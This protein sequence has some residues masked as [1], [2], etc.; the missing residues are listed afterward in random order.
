MKFKQIKVSTKIGQAAIFLSLLVGSGTSSADQ[1]HY[2]NLLIGDRAVGLGGAFGAVSDDAS[3]VFYNPAGLGFALSNDVSGSAN[4]VYNRKITYEKAIGDLDFVENTSGTI[5]SFFGILQKLDHIS[6]GLVFALGFYTTDSDLKDQDDL[7]EGAEL[8]S[9][10]TSGTGKVK[11]HRYHRTV[12]VRGST[13]F[14]GIALSKRISGGLSVGLGLT[15][16]SV[17]ELVQE[18]QDTRSQG[19]GA[20]ADGTPVVS[21]LIGHQTQNIRQ[22]LTAT[23]TQLAFGLQWAFA[24]RFSLGITAKGGAWVSSKLDNSFEKMLAG[25]PSSVSDALANGSTGKDADGKSQTIG[26]TFSQV[27]ASSENDDALGSMSAEATVAFAWFIS[28]RALYTLDVSWHD[29]VNDALAAYQKE[30]VLNFASGL[31]YYVTPSLAV[32]LGAFTNNDAR[33]KLDKAAMAQRDH[34]DFMGESMF[35]AWV[36]PNSQIAAGVILQQGKGEAQKTGDLNI[37]NV[38]GDS[39]TF[40]FSTGRTKLS[41]K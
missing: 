8:T 18:Y 19:I 31:E 30:A 33:P 6:K 13:S 35:L 16:V 22:Y 1:F 40:A 23:G 36:Q 9:R 39:F 5:P 25:V 7:I 27:G 17:D 15:Y 41:L 21:S 20:D 28:T 11:L 26:V 14:K 4:A 32:R 2:R 34:I 38:V 37:Q 12:N 3:G 24:G 29:A 10:T